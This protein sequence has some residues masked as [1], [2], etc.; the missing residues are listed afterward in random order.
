[1]NDIAQVNAPPAIPPEF[2]LVANTYLKFGDLEV[3][4]D[5]LNMAK[6]LIVDILEKP[7]IKRY[8]DGVFLHQGYMNRNTIV[9]MMEEIITSKLEEAKE[10]GMYSKKDLADLIKMAHDMRIQ[11][12]KVAD[13]GP[14]TQTNVQI[15]D[16]NVFGEGNY[17]KLMEKLL[18]S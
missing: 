8:I 3:V 1:M 13:K 15:N 14:R 17:G 6:H 10:S 7:E 5:Q 11:E 9:E 4:S 16:S 18:G 2:L 12:I